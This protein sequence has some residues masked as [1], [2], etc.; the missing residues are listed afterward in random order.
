MTDSG[1]S[2]QLEIIDEL[3][4]LPIIEKQMAL[5]E[6]H[7]SVIRNMIN[8]IKQMQNDV[9]E[10]F[11]EVMKK[12]GCRLMEMSGKTMKGFVYV[13]KEVLGSN[14][15]LEYWTNLALEYNKIAKS[16]KKKDR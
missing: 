7:G 9:S 11:E 5:T 4:W 6:S 2:E 12:E 15:N 14:K 13:D 8:G 1:Q 16:A 3:G 10:K